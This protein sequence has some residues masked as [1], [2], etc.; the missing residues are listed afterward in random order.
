MRSAIAVSMYPGQTALTRIPSRACPL[1]A[2]FV[3]PMT[4]CLLA[5]YAG[6]RADPM[7]PTIEAVLTMAP[8]PCAAMWRISCLRQRHTPVKFTARIRSQSA[9]ASSVSDPIGPSMPALL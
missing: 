1:A 7:T 2:D 6:A 8:P 5:L 4:P 9:S 3:R